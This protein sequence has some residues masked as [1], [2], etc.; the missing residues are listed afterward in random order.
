[1]IA[2]G[3]NRGVLPLAVAVVDSECTASWLFFMD[4]LYQCIGSDNKGTPYTFMSDRQK[5]CILY[6]YLQFISLIPESLLLLTYWNVYISLEQ[7][8]TNAIEAWFPSAT[9][10]FYCQHIFSNFK[11]KFPGLRLR[12]EFWAAA[13]ATTGFEFWETIKILKTVGE[14]KPAD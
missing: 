4:C 11:K 13:R 9:H 1:M 3:R 7:G 12:K 10:R 6:L 5:V 2:P 8:L 14:G